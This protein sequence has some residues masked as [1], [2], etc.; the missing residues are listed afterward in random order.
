MAGMLAARVLADRCG[1]VTIVERDELPDGPISRRGLPQAGHLHIVLARGQELLEGWFPGLR[2]ELC[3][4]GA[5]DIDAG[6]EVGWLT[7]FGWASHFD[8]G[9]I[10]NL[11][12]TRDFLDAHVRARLK[13]DARVRWIEGVQIEALLLDGSRVRGVR[14]SGGQVI[15][16]EIVVDA[17]GRGSKLPGWLCDAGVPAPREKVVETGLIY[18]SAL[19]RLRRPMPNGWKALIVGAAPPQ[20]VAGAFMSQVE[21]GRALV[22]FAGAGLA[23]PETQHAAAVF[24][25]GLRSPVIAEL[26]ED[27]ELLAP[28][29]LTRSTANRRRLY[30]EL[31]LPEG[32][33]P[34]GDSLCSFNPIYG[35]GI[36]VAALEAQ[37]LSRLS[38]DGRLSARAVKSFASIAAFPWMAATIDD[39]RYPTVRGDRPKGLR[40]L[41]GY[42]DRIFAAGTRDPRT[43]QAFVRTLQFL[44]PPLA[45]YAPRRL[46]AALRQP[47]PRALLGPV[48]LPQSEGI[49]KSE[50]ELALR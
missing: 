23:M 39:F 1:A 49:C 4:D 34:I 30:E 11:W 18:A 41:H 47:R 15:E 19:V 16:A 43:W 8:R 32:L 2:K 42:L 10:E 40:F 22:T 21:G 5:I 36:T 17:T 37:A 24:A 28:L 29:R 13:R 20:S 44:A 14:A 45:L 3:V 33:V 27:A 7:P 38:L 26:L 50:I 48:V 12:L 6:A 25:R 31:R 35:Q 9:S 46:W